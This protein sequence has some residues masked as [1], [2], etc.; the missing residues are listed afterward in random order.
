MSS[1]YLKLIMSFHKNVCFI[2]IIIKYW[3]S[4]LAQPTANKIGIYF[5]GTCNNS[6][7]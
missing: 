5:Y 7:G 4:P 3:K 6:I 1:K 2:L